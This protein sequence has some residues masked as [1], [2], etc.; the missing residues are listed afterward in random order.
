MPIAVKLSNTGIAIKLAPQP[1]T[2]DLSDVSSGTFVAVLQFGGGTTGITYGTQIGKFSKIGNKVLVS[3][4]IQLTSK[5]T[6]VGAAAIAG[7]PFVPDASLFQAGVVQINNMTIT[8]S[9]QCFINSGGTPSI[10][11]HQQTNGV[12]AALTDANFN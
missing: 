4:T 1:A 9:P 6:S 8:G 3:L 2:T 10:L 5:G 12:D 11:L 7:L